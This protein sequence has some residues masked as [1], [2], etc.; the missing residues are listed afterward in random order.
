VKLQD[1]DQ[2]HSEESRDKPPLPIPF[3]TEIVRK[4]QPGKALDLA[5]GTG[6]HALW[7]AREGWSVTAV[8]GSSA[9]IG[10]LNEQKGDLLIE[11][12]IADLEQHDYTI[13]P[14]AWDLIVISLYLQRDLFEPAKLGVKPGG[15]LIAITLLSNEADLRPHRLGPGEL[16]SYFTGW[17]I[18]NYFEGSVNNSSSQARIVARGPCN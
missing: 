7:L 2:R 11:T 1:W 3:I 14:Q 13:T 8:D 18:L 9:A 10:I 15:I 17:E 5:C 12:R 6:R 16:K 4:L